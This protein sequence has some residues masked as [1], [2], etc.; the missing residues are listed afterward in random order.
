VRWEGEEG[1]VGV[2]THTRRARARVLSPL[3]L[4]PSTTPLSP[5]KHSHDVSFPF[6]QVAIITGA[7]QGLGAS[8][9]RLFASHGA[10]VL[11]ADLDGPKAEGV[12][13]SIRAGGGHAASFA[14]DVTDPAFAPACVRAA[15]DAFG[16]GSI[17]ILVNNA[18]ENG[19]EGFLFF[20]FR[21]SCHSQPCQSEGGG[22][23]FIPLLFFSSISSH[24][25]TQPLPS[26]Q[27]YTWDGVIH[28]LTG[29]AWDAMLAVHCTAPFRLI[30][31][32]APFMRDAAKAEMAESATGRP[33]PR[34]IINVSSTSGAH[35]N[36]GQA[37]Y[38]TAKAGVLGLTKTIA[39]EWGALGIRANAVTY[40][41]IAT[42]L[43]GEKGAASVT[44]GGKEV[45]LGIPGGE[46]VASA[47][48]EM[49]IPLR[50]VGSPEEAAGAMLLLASPYASFISGQ[51]LEVT[52]G[53]F[54]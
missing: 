50:R 42:R 35:G 53:A 8:A 40:G 44:V 34:C 54:I 13:A 48:A 20:F 46:A 23:F 21:F 39:R 22:G 37:N 29:E 33:R 12:A 7:G 9:A 31:A 49:L 10:R 18:G 26:I 51:S 47:A 5:P 36:A 41:F 1:V 2:E 17:D 30:Q 27:G 6:Q 16:G 19:M 52:G 32:A 4:H 14:G 43:T 24:A 11:V 25:K 3:S 38:A 15:L 45:P 28:R